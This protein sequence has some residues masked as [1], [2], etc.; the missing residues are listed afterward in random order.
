M[1]G[2]FKKSKGFFSQKNT[3]DEDVMDSIQFNFLLKNSLFILPEKQTF[4]STNG[5]TFPNKIYV[6]Y[7]LFKKFVRP[8]NFEKVLNH[9][10]LSIIELQKE[11]TTFQLHI[12]LQG[13]SVTA[14][15]KFKGLVLMFYEK[16]GV[17]YV[18]TIDSIYIYYTPSVFDT[19]KTI[20]KNLSS[21]SNTFM[22]EP[23]LYSAKE[24]PAL[25]E[26]LL[27]GRRESLAN[28]NAPYLWEIPEGSAVE[29]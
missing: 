26:E 14:A 5:P 23:V 10:I 8:S 15:E 20:F 29:V 6:D 16:Y 9:F 12:N 28:T 1:D 11:C 17:D 22:F 25:L 24:S 21:L 27:Q 7:T 2:I 3:T 19:I 18:N 13:F 4:Q